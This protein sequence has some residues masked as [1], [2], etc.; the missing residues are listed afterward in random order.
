QRPYTLLAYKTLFRSDAG[1]GH[2]RSPA[3]CV[4]RRDRRGGGRLQDP[5]QGRNLVPAAFRALDVP[6]NLQFLRL[7]TV[8]PARAPRLETGRTDRKSTRM[9]SSHWKI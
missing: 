3:Q 1:A 7:G 8:R 5:V 2:R 6:Q 9:N 4:L